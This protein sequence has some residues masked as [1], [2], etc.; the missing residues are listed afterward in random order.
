MTSIICAGSIALD[1][2]R[3]PLRTVERVLG[4]AASFFS[5]SAS[6]FAPVS[7]LGVVGS[8]FPPGYLQR[9]SGRKGI[10]ASGVVR[11]REKSPFF[12]MSFDH[13]LHT[14]TVNASELNCLA[15]YVPE[16]PKRLGQKN[17]LLYLAT[18]PPAHQLRI[19]KQAAKN[20]LCVMDTISYYIENDVE[21]LKK[22]VSAVD[23]I[24][25]NDAEA[26]MLSQEGNL[27]KA[28]RKI[29]AMGPRFLAIKKGEHGSLLFFNGAVYPFP[30]FPLYDVVDPT[31][32]GDSF[33]GG[34]MGFLAKKQA[35]R[36]RLRLKDLRQA[37][38]CATVMGSF[39]VEDFSV[40][41]LESITAKDIT[42]RYGELESAVHW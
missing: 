23:G 31:G 25:L 10:D 21:D 18:M 9:L 3:T 8:D 2:I 24:V 28:G 35:T 16:V 41:R 1:T 27:L 38:A 29:L 14:R 26:R 42:K 4:G 37:M 19:L 33:A 7:L 39:A 32:A 30:A 17:S 6:F 12:D 40:A 20:R 15:S 11:S 22:T 36:E 34:L 5:L 13:S